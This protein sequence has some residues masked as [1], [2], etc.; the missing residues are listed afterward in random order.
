M[1]IIRR[2]TPSRPIK[3]RRH[4]GV[5]LAPFG[6]VTGSQLGKEESATTRGNPRPTW[7]D[8]ARSA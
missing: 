8:C 5:Q 1:P 2:V 4:E 3:V 6:L 7:R